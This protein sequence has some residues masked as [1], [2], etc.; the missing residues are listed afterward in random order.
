MI[1][2]T[3]K[4]QGNGAGRAMIALLAAF[5]A[6]AVLYSRCIPLWMNSDEP[7]HYYYIK[8]IMN[9][10]RLAT[11]E[12]TYE[13]AQPP[14]YYAAA[15]VWAAPFS[16]AKPDFLDRWLR[17][18][19]VVLGTLVLYVMYRIG[20]DCFGDGWLG[21]GM[22]LFAAANPMFAAA[23]AVVNNDI[24]VTLACS[25]AIYFIL[26]TTA[27]G[28]GFAAA[29]AC[30]AAAGAACLVK[31]NASLLVP[32]FCL[33]YFFHPELRPR[34]WTRRVAEI[35]VFCLVCAAVCA[36]W[37]AWRYASIG[38]SLNLNPDLTLKPTPLYLPG[39]FAWFVKAN[40]MNFWLPQDYLRGYPVN[41]PFAGKLLYF[42]LSAACVVAAVFCVARTRRSLP[43]P[44]RSAIVWFVFCFAAFLGQMFLVNLT[45]EAAQARYM[46]TILAP[47]ALL[48]ILPFRQWLG[49]KLIPA[50]I[51]AAALALA[52][53]LVW[54]LVFLLP[55][56]GPN[57]VIN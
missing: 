54:A 9:E 45:V 53:H 43:A 19:S 36:W 37:Y 16:G 55:I 4:P 8:T 23:S 51:A 39:N 17:L 5:F 25:A 52:S 10:R 41:F 29:A 14:L 40:M 20:R 44:Q 49:Q 42:G 26:K 48:V 27:R 35:A 50:F 30:G 38:N 46:F 11:H 57:F 2:E 1:P 28:G 24:A 6:V 15:A 12:D 34:P 21:A 47:A 22:A 7:F 3:G 32:F 13:A 33:F 56:K 18:F 31:F